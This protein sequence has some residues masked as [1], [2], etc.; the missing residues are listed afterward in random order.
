MKL[1]PEMRQIP[2]EDRARFNLLFFLQHY[3]PRSASIQ[4]MRDEAR[5]RIAERVRAKGKGKVIPV[6]RV[7]TLSPADFRE[8][9]LHRGVPVILEGAAAEWTC[10]RRWSFEGFK[11]RLGKQTI[12]LVDRKGLTDDDFVHEREYSEEIEFGAFLDQ[13]LA[14]GKKYMR[15]SPLLERFPELREDFDGKFF[16]AL[17]GRVFGV[18]HHMFIGGRGSV[19]PLHNAVTP[20]FF[21]NV[22]GVKRWSF[23]PNHYLALLDPAADG[24][25]Y[26]HSAAR[27]DLANVEMF[28]GFECVDRLET[29]MQPG[30][31]L[32]VPSWLWHC[33]EN[34]SPTIG[35]RYGLYHPRSMVTESYTLFLVRVLAARNPTVL[36]GL[37][38]SLIQTDLPQRDKEMLIAKM[39]RG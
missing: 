8:R 19:T 14:G 24:F 17:M 2:L 37:Y 33:V 6:E 29:V 32:Y 36:E 35:L 18:I 5:A 7:K 13:A 21:V 28:P 39:F 30:D 4:S 20:F 15:F 1:L 23:V 38:Y 10:S 22:C 27:L 3:L 25:G 16:H 26:N 31:A 9:Y 12:K 34:E 11:E